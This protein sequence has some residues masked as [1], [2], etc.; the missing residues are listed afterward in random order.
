MQGGWRPFLSSLAEDMIMQS[1]SWAALAAVMLLASTSIAN[2]QETTLLGGTGE[3]TVQ[4]LLFDGRA[5]TEQ[6]YYRGWGG[7][8][9]WGWG[10]YRGWGV[11]YRGWG[12]GGWG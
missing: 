4:S 11:G 12:W 7:H 6:V 3:A 5:D 1:F 2:A 10:G 9:G 8:R